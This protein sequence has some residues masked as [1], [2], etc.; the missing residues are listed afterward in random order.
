[1]RTI[2]HRA[3]IF[4][5]AIAA[6]IAL[7]PRAALARSCPAHADGDIGA[8]WRSLGGADGPLGCPTAPEKPHP[9][10]ARARAQPFERGQISW[11]PGAG[12]HVTVVAWTEGERIVVDWSDTAPFNYDF[13][14]V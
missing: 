1:M 8:K 4:G 7:A 2:V 14:I 6:A 3:A 9:D 10:D 5:P 12:P 13:F 11:S